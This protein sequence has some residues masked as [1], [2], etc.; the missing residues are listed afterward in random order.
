MT[1]NFHHWTLQ[2]FSCLGHWDPAAPS[3]SSTEWCVPVLSW[4]WTVQPGVPSVADHFLHL[5]Q[6][7]TCCTLHLSHLLTC[8]LNVVYSTYNNLFLYVYV[9]TY[10]LSSWCPTPHTLSSNYLLVPLEKPYLKVFHDFRPKVETFVST[11]LSL[12][13]K[14]PMAP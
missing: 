9:H 4:V 8:F 10:S 7:S 3:V 13:P 1:G 6:L 11:L 2:A 12:H 14:P 5:G